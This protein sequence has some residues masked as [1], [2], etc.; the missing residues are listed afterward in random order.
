[1]NIQEAIVDS[2]IKLA[3]DISADAILALTETGQ[4]YE[5]LKKQSGD[6]KVIALTANESTYEDLVDQ[7]A[8]VIDLSV[9]DPTRMGQIRHAVWRGLNGGLLSPKDLV[10]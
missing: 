6:R 7:D 1:M 8:K 3:K 10:V 9:R 5:L 2:A 4:T